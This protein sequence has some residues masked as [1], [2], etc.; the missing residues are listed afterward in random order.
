VAR[1]GSDHFVAE[2]GRTI[3]GAGFALR[4]PRAQ[5]ITTA[6]GRAARVSM[7]DASLQRRARSDALAP[8]ADASSGGLRGTTIAA[9]LALVLLAVEWWLVRS[10]R[11]P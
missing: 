2:D 11:M 3:D 6:T 5:T 7:L 4:L 9:L 1:D 10:E 8:V